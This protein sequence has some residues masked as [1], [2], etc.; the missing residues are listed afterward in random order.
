MNGFVRSAS[1]LPREPLYQSDHWYKF[2]KAIKQLEN[3]GYYDSI[4]SPFVY[5]E[6][7]YI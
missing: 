2:F 4:I 3:I 7:R 1:S 5:V 6:T